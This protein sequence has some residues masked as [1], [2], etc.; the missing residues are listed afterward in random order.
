MKRRSAPEQTADSFGISKNGR[1]RQ[2]RRAENGRNEDGHKAARMLDDYVGENINPLENRPCLAAAEVDDICK[3][4]TFEAT[5]AH[6]KGAVYNRARKRNGI[7]NIERLVCAVCDQRIL[8]IG[9]KR[10]KPGGNAALRWRAK[11]R[12][13]ENVP[14]V[15]RKYY[16]V[17]GVVHELR[18]SLLSQSGLEKR[19]GPHTGYLILC[20]E[21]FRAMKIGNKPPKFAIAIGFDIGKLPGFLQDGNCMERRLISLTAVAARMTVLKGGKHRAIKWHVSVMHMNPVSIARRLP[22]LLQSDDEQ[23]LVVFTLR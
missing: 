13:S 6:T 20:P 5:T 17:S 7:D 8:R 14:N 16:D 10:Y 3:N 2:R 1:S 9:V 23:F 11:L 4:R 12:G 18:G 21:C 22:N 19:G 15:L